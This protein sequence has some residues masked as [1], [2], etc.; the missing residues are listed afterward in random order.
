MLGKACDLIADAERR[1]AQA[2]AE[3]A[4]Q[5]EEISVKTF[6]YSSISKSN[7]SSTAYAKN[8]EDNDRC[9]KNCCCHYSRSMEAHIVSCDHEG[10]VHASPHRASSAPPLH[11]SPV[12]KGKAPAPKFSAHLGDLISSSYSSTV[13]ESSALSHSTDD[14]SGGGA[15]LYTT[16]F[17]TPT[18]LVKRG[19]HGKR[20]RL[21][22][23]AMIQEI[24][25]RSYYDYSALD[26]DENEIRDNSSDENCT[27]KNID[28]RLSLVSG[29]CHTEDCAGNASPDPYD[30]SFD[31]RAGLLA[32][33]MVNL[34]SV[35]LNQGP[36]SPEMERVLLVT[37]DQ[38]CVEDSEQGLQ[39]LAH[40][41]VPSSVGSA[42]SVNNHPIQGYREI[43]LKSNFSCQCLEN[44]TQSSSVPV[45][46]ASCVENLPCRSVT[47]NE[48]DS[49]KLNDISE[50]LK[51]INDDMTNQSN[52]NFSFKAASAPDVRLTKDSDDET[53]LDQ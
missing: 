20:V 9:C 48:S 40:D 38:T 10:L 26:D 32:N 29:S 39:S 47:V 15:M 5:T 44:T 12:G 1:K 17:T 27:K 18:H 45:T 51:D 50:K 41:A 16:P 22:S 43:S 4:K 46:E 33:S 3:A 19:A 11:S 23:G 52:L 6:T 37:E 8:T 24:E 49:D 36:H 30:A 31:S 14:A 25:P 35:G 7:T 21:D 34:A 2:E 13:S 42:T 28:L 53:V